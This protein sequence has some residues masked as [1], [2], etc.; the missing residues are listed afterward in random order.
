MNLV[1][2]TQGFSDFINITDLVKQAIK[3]K[4]ILNGLVFLFVKGTTAGLALIEDEKGHLEDLKEVLEQIAPSDKNYQHHHN[5]YDHNGAAHI[6]AAFLKQDLVIPL[7]N[8]DLEL[9]SWQNIFLI[10]VDDKP[11]QREIVVQI[12]SL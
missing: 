4:N 8:G 6:K 7:T 10:D 5:G 2:N 1:I 9:G 12:I 3:R 11:R